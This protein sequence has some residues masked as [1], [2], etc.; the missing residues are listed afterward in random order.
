MTSAMLFKHSSALHKRLW[1]ALLLAAS[2]AISCSEGEFLVD[3]EADVDCGPF[4]Q[5]VEDQCHCLA[6]L[7]PGFCAGSSCVPLECTQQGNRCDVEGFDLCDPVADECYRSNGRCEGPGDCPSF[8]YDE[9]ERVCGDDGFCHYVSPE[10]AAPLLASAQLLPVV[11]PVNGQ[12]F[13]EASAT[14]FSWFRQPGPV[15]AAVSASRPMYPSDLD[16]SIWAAFLSPGST[17]VDWNQG[18]SRGEGGWTDPAVEPPAGEL[19]LV[20]VGYEGSAVVSMSQPIAFRVGSDWPAVGATC[21]PSDA[22]FVNCE[23]PDQVLACDRGSCERRCLSHVDCI[24]IGESRCGPGIPTR[25]RFCER[26]RD[27]SSAGG[28]PAQEGG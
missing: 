26:S 19:Y 8:G 18:L 3:C 14:R 21:G 17:G 12:H 15:I 2:I 24:G 9:H 10:D 11:E 27:V 5:C 16:A 20:V 6:D 13:D 28:A 22:A 4:G 23:V 7:C 25:G 1:M